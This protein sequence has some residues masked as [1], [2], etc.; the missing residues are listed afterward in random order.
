M[1]L[2]KT[3]AAIMVSVLML[4][5]LAACGSKGT[6]NSGSGLTVI[7]IASQSP[8]SGGS[9]LQGEAIKLG[10]QMALDERKEDFKKLGFDLQL[11]PYDD[12]GDSKKGVANAEMIGADKEILAVLG[13]MNSG[14]SI[15]SS[16]VYEKYNIPMVSP[17]NTAT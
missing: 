3:F 2:K 10:G 8:L 1:N 17:A 14:V 7:K 4:S 12:Q 9:S 13:H 15:P 16:V 11:V 5:I 6:G